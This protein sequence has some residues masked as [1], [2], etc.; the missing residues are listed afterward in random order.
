[1]KKCLAIVSCICLMFS[2]L[3]LNTVTV[4]AATYSYYTSWIDGYQFYVDTTNEIAA[5]KYADTA[6]KEGEVVIPSTYNN[7]PIVSI[8][9][10]A[11]ASCNKI[12]GIV[13]PDSVTI[14]ENSA[15]THC[16]AKFVTIPNSVID[17]GSSA[18]SNCN[19][20]LSISIPNSI[21]VIK[22]STFRYCSNLTKIILPVTIDNINDDAFENCSKLTDVWY[23]GSQTD[24]ESIVIGK[25]NYYLTNAIWHYDSCPVGAPHSY[26]NDC[27]ETC[28]GCGKIRT[29]SGHSYDNTCD[30]I[31][32]ICNETRETSHTYDNSCDTQCNICNNSRTISHTYGEWNVTKPASCTENGTKT[33]KCGVCSKTESDTIFSLGHDFSTEWTV[34]KNATCTT[35]GSKSKHCIRCTEISDVTTIVARGHDWGKWFI[36][37][38]ATTVEEGVSARTCNDCK[39]K[40]TQTIAK[41]ASDGHTHD[42]GDWRIIKVATCIESGNA[43][44]ECVICKVQEEKSLLAT[45]H[46]VGEWIEISATCTNAGSRERA[47]I[48]CGE[49]E[50]III[51]ALGHDFDNSIVIKEPTSDE[52]GLKEGKCKRCGETTTEEIPALPN[53]NSA[54]SNLPEA[55]GEGDDKAPSRTGDY[56]WII[57]LAGVILLGVGIGVAFVL[58][59]RRTK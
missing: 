44:R 10:R 40:E 49:T 41:L 58:K 7:Y 19:N 32:N 13:V 57:V 11:F 27:D 50:K 53:I 22:K 36:E 25:G 37:K 29:V 59:K 17:I 20:L 15:F 8:C 26:D 1:M 42:F 30:T 28:N 4:N 35:A 43:T 55:N 34:D 14:I 3:S 33:R 31:C 12:T 6:M 9:E 39:L 51:S 45:G 46:Q 21:T 38:E 23:T 56:K 52:S 47:C 54:V 5:I 18:F 2:L 16:G 24:R 48:V